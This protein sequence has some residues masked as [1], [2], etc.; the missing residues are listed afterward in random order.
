MIVSGEGSEESLGAA[1]ALSDFAAAEGAVV[2]LDGVAE[3]GAEGAVL[4]AGGVGV[5]AAHG[6]AAVRTSEASKA[7]R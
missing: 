1:V 7:K 2:E 4:L 6:A 3:E 5:C